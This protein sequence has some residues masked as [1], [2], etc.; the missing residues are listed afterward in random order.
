MELEDIREAFL[1]FD[2]E[3]KG[4]ISAQELRNVLLHL[5]KEQNIPSAGVLETLEG[6]P[7]D[8]LLSMDE[9]VDLLTLRGGRN[10]DRDE[11]RKI[12]DMFDASGKGYIE[13]DDLRAVATSLGETLSE[14]EL[15]EMITRASSSGQSH[16][17]YEDFTAI[18]TKKLFS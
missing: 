9:F 7:E 8:G 14:E 2:T 10:D 4:S 1:L 5:S 17:T 13:M 6:L 11:L 3:K 12:F 16:V 15:Q 18:M